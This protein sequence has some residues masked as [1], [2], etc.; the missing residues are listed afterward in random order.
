MSALIHTLLPMLFTGLRLTILIAILGIVFA[1]VI[2]SISGY[3]LQSKSRIA[4]AIAFIYIWL[5][6]GTPLVV[7]ALYIYYVLPLIVPFL[8]L[9]S[10]TAGIV[11]IS[12]NSGAFIAEIIRGALQGVDA[13]QKETGA[14][15]GMTNFQVLIHLVIPPAFRAVI[16]ALFNQFIIALKDTS[17]LTVIVVNEMTQMAMSYSSLNFRY[18]EAYTALAVFY[19][20]LISVLVVIQKFV[21]RKLGVNSPAKPKIANL[22][23]KLPI[24]N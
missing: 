2:G 13:G 22:R 6:R 4:R 23:V 5:I 15:L 11:V 24:D 10:T 16:P 9:S 17:L 7:Q 8:E 3:A 14:S 21:E 1:F 19:L 12:I 20:V 18:I